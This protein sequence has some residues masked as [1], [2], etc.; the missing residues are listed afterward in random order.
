MFSSLAVG[1]M[2]S[3]WHASQ[4]CKLRDNLSI[5][6]QIKSGCEKYNCNNSINKMI[7]QFNI[8]TGNGNAYVMTENLNGNKFWCFCSS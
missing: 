6:S 2:M 4:T 3:S 5:N 7:K 8:S 1:I